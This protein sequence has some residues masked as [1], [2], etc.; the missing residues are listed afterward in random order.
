M[1][2]TTPPPSDLEGGLRGLVADEYGPVLDWTPLGGEDDLN[3][4][5]GLSVATAFV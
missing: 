5:V 1:S 4:R 2:F 3:V